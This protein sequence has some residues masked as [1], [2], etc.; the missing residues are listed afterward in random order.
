[1]TRLNSICFAR[2][3]NIASNVKKATIANEIGHREPEFSTLLRN[4]NRKL[5]EVFEVQTKK[6]YH[7]VLITGSGT[8]ANEAILA[9]VIGNR[10]ILI[11]SNGEFGER[12]I[13]ISQLHNKKTKSI[14]FGWAEQIN[15]EKI[16]KFIESNK[17]EV[18]MMAHHETSSGMLNPIDRV[19]PMTK[20]LG[21]QF[22]VDAVSSAGVEKI[23]L[24]N[25]NISFCTTSSGKAFRFW[26][27]HNHRKSE[28]F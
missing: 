22:I 25:W 14:K 19:G 6:L 20:R 28:R 11:V 15:L 16:E 1:M 7:P 17:I 23:D 12:L 5:L 26:S 27:W 8:A 24:E 4:V 21:V 13:K 3:V 10:S 9:S 18:L 2:E